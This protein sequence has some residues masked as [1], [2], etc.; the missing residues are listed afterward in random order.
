MDLTSPNTSPNAY[1]EPTRRVFVFVR[2]DDGLLY[3][4]DAASGRLTAYRT[5]PGLRYRALDGSDIENV[6]PDEYARFD[7]LT[8]QGSIHSYP[9][10][11][12]WVNWTPQGEP[13]KSDVTIARAAWNEDFPPAADT[14]DVMSIPRLSPVTIDEMTGED[15]DSVSAEANA[16]LVTERSD[17]M[18]N[19]GTTAAVE[20]RGFIPEAQWA[21]G[22]E[23]IAPGLIDQARDIAAT[24]ENWID[25]VARAMSTVA[26]ADYQRRLLN[27]QLDRARQ[28]LPPLESSQYGM[29][30]NVGVNT[31]TALLIGGIALVALLALRRS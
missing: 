15:I 13:G 18:D 23:T 2:P 22:I 11:G 17:T 12:Y 31:Q 6:N 28:G 16:S 5:A 4:R 9:S 10:A 3:A 24:G 19:F 30:L 8:G 29:G 21:G 26:M 1:W 14:R 25:S 20:D 7:P 27:V